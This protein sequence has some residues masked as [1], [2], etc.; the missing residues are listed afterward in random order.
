[1]AAGVTQ[2]LC[3]R[4][5]LERTPAIQAGHLTAAVGPV[6]SGL[7]QLLAADM[8]GALRTDRPG[9][10]PTHSARRYHGRTHRRR[11]YAVCIRARRRGGCLTRGL[12]LKGCAFVRASLAGFP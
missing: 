1:N 4:D 9:T 10:H 12:Q 3:L 8:R 5:A 11:G 6:V 7:R 2:A